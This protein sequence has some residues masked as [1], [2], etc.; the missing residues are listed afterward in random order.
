M[1]DQPTGPK[2][3]P[4]SVAGLLS[5]E[6]DKAIVMIIS[7][8][9]K[10]SLFNV[11]TYGTTP[12]AKDL[13]VK[14]SSRFVEVISVDEN[15]KDVYEDFQAT[16]QAIAQAAIDELRREVVER[17]AIIEALKKQLEVRNRLVVM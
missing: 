11:S 3:I 14:W 16:P 15:A 8:D 12:G 1:S 6:Y 2:N 5:A 13:A 4:T 9:L 10:H 17:D 7:Y